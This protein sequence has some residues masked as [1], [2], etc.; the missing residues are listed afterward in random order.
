MLKKP[1]VRVRIHLSPMNRDGMHTNFL[2]TAFCKFGGR[3]IEPLLV[4]HEDGDFMVTGALEAIFPGGTLDDPPLSRWTRLSSPALT[5]EDVNEILCEV[6]ESA[7]RYAYLYDLDDD[8]APG[9]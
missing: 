1:R 7:S 5:P 4:I 2:G 8:A 9:V 6:D 3:E